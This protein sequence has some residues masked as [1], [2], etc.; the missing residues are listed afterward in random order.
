MWL[1]TFHAS[2]RVCVHYLCAGGEDFTRLRGWKHRVAECRGFWNYYGYST[3]TTYITY[4][5]LN[6]LFLLWA[7]TWNTNRSRMIQ[8]WI[9]HFLSCYA[10]SVNILV[11]LKI[12]VTKIIYLFNKIVISSRHPK[13]SIQISKRNF[14]K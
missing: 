3:D 1:Y 8:K 9:K 13:L 12:L 10:Q 11:K 4:V 2:V 5:M 6:E 7:W 14:F